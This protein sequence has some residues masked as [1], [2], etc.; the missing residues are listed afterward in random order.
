M[1]SKDYYVLNIIFAA[2]I[3]CLLV[4]GFFIDSSAQF[5]CQVLEQTGKECKSC[6]LTRDFVSFNQLDFDNPI[7]EHSLKLYTWFL[8]QLLI[9]ILLLLIPSGVRSKLIVY[10]L[11][12][13]MVSAIYVFVPLWI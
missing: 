4:S 12:F 2:L 1:S 3:F 9:R 6:G 8:L 13:L 10:D 5:S 11:I 7:N